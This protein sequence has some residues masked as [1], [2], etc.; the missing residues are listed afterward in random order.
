[1]C[2]P[3]TGTILTV[4]STLMSAKAARDQG[5]YQKDMSN[6]NARVAEN[7]AEEVRNVG[8]EEENKQRRA[9]AQLLS[10]QRARLG[11]SGLELGSG[12]ALQLQEET[13][14]LGEIDAGRI[15]SNYAD[16]ATSLDTGAGLTRIEGANAAKAGNNRAF[17]TLLSGGAKVAGKWYDDKS[18]AN[19]P[20]PIRDAMPAYN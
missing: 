12:S 14:E 1:M 10:K 13:E 19:N 4:A 11:A 9:T 20:A 5:Q 2:D 8:V 3:V 7:E 6:Y 18:A 17:G 16:K 15:K